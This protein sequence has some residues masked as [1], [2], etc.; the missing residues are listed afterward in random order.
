MWVL[1]FVY[2]Y[3]QDAH[4]MTHSVHNSLS[5]CFVARDILAAE[6]GGPSYGQFPLGQQALC[7]VETPDDVGDYL[8]KN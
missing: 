8:K 1:V 2:L 4:G 3:G 7:I 6:Q 5:D